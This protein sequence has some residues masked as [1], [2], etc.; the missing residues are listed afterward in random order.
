MAIFYIVAFFL[1]GFTSLPIIPSHYSPSSAIFLLL[2]YLVTYKI[3]LRPKEKWSFFLLFFVFWTSIATLVNILL[4]TVSALSALNG[5]LAL[6]LGVFSIYM[7]CS[8]FRHVK[9]EVV[10][11]TILWSLN[12]I[13]AV[14]CIEILN[15]IGLLPQSIE[16]LIVS[17]ISKTVV[18][19]V[20][21]T[22][23][24]AS[25]AARLMLFYIP[26][27]VWMNKAG[28]TTKRQTRTYGLICL[29][30]LM[31]TMSLSA[32]VV[33]SVFVP[34]YLFFNMYAFG[35][36]SYVLRVLINVTSTTLLFFF[37]ISVLFY[38]M[39][40]MDSYY[41]NRVMGFF[42]FSGGGV[43]DFIKERESL[44]VRVYYPLAALDM[45]LHNPFGGGV[46][47][48]ADQFNN[49]MV[50]L[51]FADIDILEVQEDMARGTADPKNMY[52]KIAAETGVVGIGAYLA[53]MFYVLRRIRLS[54]GY[55]STPQLK[56]LIMVFAMSAAA[57]V[58]GGSFAYIPYCFT[59]ALVV[60]MTSRRTQGV[61][62]Q[63][64]QVIRKAATP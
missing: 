35:L 46:G 21:L 48:F 12:F 52:F 44:F 56:G 45:F 2:S 6:G 3:D 39:K 37:V 28:M 32:A 19:R 49:A 30:F 41:V 54:R 29:F 13:F 42:S 61:A 57:Q 31:S 25:W 9:E 10:A 1:V 5:F 33:F 64:H 23:S 59:I 16:D 36:N 60:S 63:E 20:Q 50:R 22:T 51:G 38:S 14:G 58:Q 62:R 40:D 8:A 43:A 24:E 26:L 7:F 17:A 34:L 4:G 11:K 55:V 18:A 47:S 15:I 53:F 27:L